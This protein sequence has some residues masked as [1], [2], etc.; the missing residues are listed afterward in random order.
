[1]ATT[2]PAKRPTDCTKRSRPRGR[3][4]TTSPMSTSTMQTMTI[5]LLSTEQG[6]DC[7]RRPTFACAWR[8]RRH[9]RAAHPW[10]RAVRAPARGRRRRRPPG[11]WSYVCAGDASPPPP[12]TRHTCTVRHVRVGPPPWCTRCRRPADATGRRR[13][14][15]RPRGPGRW[16]E[17]ARQR[18][19]PARQ[20]HR[21]QRR[22]RPA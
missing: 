16:V 21:D 18:D 9:H 15:S 19:M 10:P 11:P 8:R 14:G 2:V 6:S 12:G 7:R 20:G 4:R 13:H 1:M 3:S 5:S 17:R 22:P